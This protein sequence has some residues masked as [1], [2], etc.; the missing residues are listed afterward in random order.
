V[1]STFTAIAD[2]RALPGRML[3]GARSS[4]PHV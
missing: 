4:G 3:V 1:W 2:A